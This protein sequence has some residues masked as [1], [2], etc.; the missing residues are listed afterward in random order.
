MSERPPSGLRETLS[1]P[2]V[3]ALTIG[4]LLVL[5]YSFLIAREILFGLVVVLLLV[6]VY[7]VF[8]LIMAIERVAAALDRQTDVA[9]ERRRRRADDEASTASTGE[10]GHA[11]DG[12]PAGDRNDARERVGDVDR[13]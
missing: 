8:R 7:A 12:R 9:V 11:T 6:A 4:S 2:A 3:I 13:G 5:V 1:S 10:T